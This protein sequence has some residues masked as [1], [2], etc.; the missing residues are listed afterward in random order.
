MS[1]AKSVAARTLQDGA[2]FACFAIDLQGQ[3]EVRASA[4]RGESWQLVERL[5][6]GAA[7]VTF[8]APLARR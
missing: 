4:E 5:W 7:G 2:C 8:S 3:R 1:V 6:F